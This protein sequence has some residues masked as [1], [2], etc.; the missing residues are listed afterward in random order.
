MKIGLIDV[1]GHNFPNLCLMKISTYHTQKGDT[2]EWWNGFMHYDRIY[3]SKVFTTEYSADSLDPCNTDEIVKGGTGYNLENMLPGKIENMCPDYNLYP[4][5]SEAHG[6]LTRGCPRDC[7]FCIVAKKEGLVSHQVS[8]LGG[9]YRGQKTIKLLDPNL[10][11]CKEH[12]FLLHQLA[13]SKAQIDFTQ[14]LDVRLTNPDNI[15]L[16]NRIKTKS[17]H[18]AW[19]N[20]NEDLTNFFQ[21]FREQSRIK[22]YRKLGVYVLTNFWSTIEQDLYR[23][24]TLRHLG[25]SPYVM[26]YNKSSAPK[27]IRHLQRWC[28]NR[29]IFAVQPDFYKF[30]PSMG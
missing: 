17:I 12:E 30:N 9:F 22:D 28:N 8:D 25:Y 15:K 4:Q 1:D 18:F 23:I 7:P 2:T 14:G 29:I 3:M 6:F 16:L 20:P 21:K 24:N 11:A 13:N 26:V 5:Y 19:D 27:V 10:L